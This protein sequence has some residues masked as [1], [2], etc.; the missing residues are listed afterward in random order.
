MVADRRRVVMGAGGIGRLRSRRGRPHRRAGRI[1]LSPDRRRP[2]HQYHR[3]TPARDRLPDVA[4]PPPGPTR[5][6]RSMLRRWWAVFVIRCC[7]SVAPFGALTGLRPSTDSARPATGWGLD[8][9]AAQQ[10]RRSVAYLAGSL[11]ERQRC[12]VARGMRRSAQ[13]RRASSRFACSWTAS[14]METDKLGAPIARRCRRSAYRSSRMP[15]WCGGE[16]GAK[17]GCEG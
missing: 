9:T 7:R 17:P 13:R 2:R 5:R 3:V 8:G 16:P 10:V 11:L 14:S 6:C 15:F 12:A 1:R 4:A